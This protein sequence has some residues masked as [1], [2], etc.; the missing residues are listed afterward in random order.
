MGA[1][2]N[3]F[4][5]GRGVHRKGDF[6]MVHKCKKPHSSTLCTGSSSVFANG[7]GIGRVKDFVCCG[8]KVM[9]GSG[10]VFAG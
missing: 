2:S 3:V 1:S 5:N 4:V 9:T 7:K 10:N 8:S 6:W